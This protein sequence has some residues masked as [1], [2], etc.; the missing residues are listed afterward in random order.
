MDAKLQQR[1]KNLESKGLLVQPVIVVVGDKQIEESYALING[2]S[3]LCDSPL[4]AANTV[5]KS[6]YALQLQYPRESQFPWMVIQ[7]RIYGIKGETDSEFSTVATLI[8][9]L[10][11]SST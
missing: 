6:F 9:D 4:K 11:N 8:S 3:Y 5:F 2:I 7:H 10:K 1:K